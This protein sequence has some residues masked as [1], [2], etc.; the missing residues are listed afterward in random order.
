MVVT[1]NWVVLFGQ[2]PWQ[3][4]LAHQSDI[5][6]SIVASD[7][8]NISTEGQLGGTQ[9]LTIRVNNSRPNAESFVFRF[10]K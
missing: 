10:V 5:S 2:W 4:R 8:H 7:H 6:T 1:D 9:Y 3:F